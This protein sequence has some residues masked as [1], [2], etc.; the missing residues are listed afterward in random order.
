MGLRS[1]T[2]SLL[3]ILIMVILS[4]CNIPLNG[5]GTE[6]AGNSIETILTEMAIGTTD[7]SDA[8]AANLALDI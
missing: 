3:V 6:I 5:T 1:I 8:S 7:A 4:A 2:N